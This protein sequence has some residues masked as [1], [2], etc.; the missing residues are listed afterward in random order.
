MMVMVIIAIELTLIHNRNSKA[1]K[2][3]YKMLV[4]SKGVKWFSEEDLTPKIKA[5]K[6]FYS[7]SHDYY[8]KI[9]DKDLKPSSK[10]MRF[11]SGDDILNY[12]NIRD[13]QDKR[14]AYD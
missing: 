9:Y 5:Y 13:Q 14:Q 1:T 6:G 12:I 11:M 10:P 8:N 4:N 7:F 2:Q 3:R